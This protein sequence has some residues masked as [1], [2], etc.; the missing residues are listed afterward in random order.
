METVY[1][2]AIVTT[3]V[4]VL[5]LAVIFRDRLTRLALRFR[6]NGLDLQAARDPGPPTLDGPGIVLD[7]SRIDRSTVKVRG[8]RFISRRSR[9]ERSNLETSSSPP[10]ADSAGE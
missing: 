8:S 2:V 7:N 5:L 9:V 4:A 3:G 1:I 6:G 10:P